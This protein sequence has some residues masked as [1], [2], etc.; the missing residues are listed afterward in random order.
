MNEAF[1]PIAVGNALISIVPVASY[2]AQYKRS[3]A[4]VT[5]WSHFLILSRISLPAKF[6][7]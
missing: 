2:Q 5:Y 6:T 1:A 3:H 4:E 7:S